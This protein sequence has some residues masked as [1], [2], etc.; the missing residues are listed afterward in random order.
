MG[1]LPPYYAAPVNPPYPPAAHQPIMAPSP[2]KQARY[3][4]DSS[5][6]SAVGIP[7][8]YSS[9]SMS[10]DNSP[11]ERN[12]NHYMPSDRVENASE[13]DSDSMCVISSEES[14][15]APDVPTTV[16]QEPQARTLIRNK[17]KKGRP[18]KV[19]LGGSSRHS[20]LISEREHN[21]SVQGQPSPP[22]LTKAPSAVTKTASAAVVSTHSTGHKSV[23]ISAHHLPHQ[24]DTNSP[25]NP[26]IFIAESSAPWAG[27][28]PHP[29]N[30]IPVPTQAPPTQEEPTLLVTITDTTNI[31]RMFCQKITY[32]EAAN[33]NLRDFFVQRWE[34][35]NGVGVTGLFSSCLISHWSCDHC[36][37]VGNSDQ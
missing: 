17:R 31:Q 2:A 32:Q 1:N 24:A 11:A 28:H 25:R 16:P 36:C 34:Q 12:N 9:G 5:D 6:K 20:R 10:Q 21:L 7:K 29:A 4:N 30:H 19:V 3:S 37:L 8:Y 33:L 35:V 26:N 14:D 23:L 13:I 27:A 18:L 22:T 15:T